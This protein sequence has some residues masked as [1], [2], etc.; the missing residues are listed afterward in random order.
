MSYIL[1]A[2]KQM[3]SILNLHV[4]QFHQSREGP[5]IQQQKNVVSHPVLH[6]SLRAALCKGSYRKTIEMIAQ[7]HFLQ[8][9]FL[10]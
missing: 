1:E 3:E 4:E 5:H 2:W 6:L 8:D 7:C 10:F 9:F